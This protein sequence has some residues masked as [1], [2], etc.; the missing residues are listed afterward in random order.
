L[1]KAGAGGS[2][3]LCGLETVASR[4]LL[5]FVI[6]SSGNWLLAQLR[7]FEARKKIVE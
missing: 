6:P 7:Q 2:W 3:P 4:Y 5:L 1:K